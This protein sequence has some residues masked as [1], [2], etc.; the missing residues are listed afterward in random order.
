M[1][2]GFDYWAAKAALDWQVEMG[3]DEAIADAPIDRYRLEDKKPAAKGVAPAPPPP[4]PTATDDI[5]TV[6]EAQRAAAGAHDLATLKTALAKFDHC[7]LKAGA[8]NMVFSGGVAGSPVMIVT[9]PPDRADDRAGHL[10]AAPSGVLIDK[11]LTAIGLGR[12][13]DG[14]VYLA[15]VLPWN[16]PQNRDPNTDEMAMMR[17]FLERHIALADPKIVV[18]M[19]N[20]P[21]QML[22]GKGGMTRLR[23]GWTE[24]AGRPAIPMFAPAYL[25]QNQA[26]KRDAWAD[27]L[28]LKARLKGMI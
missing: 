7:P 23:G 25:M 28:A 4:A 16:P 8:R 19:G 13:G 2:S 5:D 12:D 9:D 24:V 26:A 17:P 15:P 21:C 20:G 27:L 6:T 1:E 22:I 3:A 18:L 14:A 11:M 10:F